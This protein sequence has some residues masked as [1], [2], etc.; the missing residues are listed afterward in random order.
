MQLTDISNLMATL[1]LGYLAN[2][3]KLSN[4]S[5]LPYLAEGASKLLYSLGM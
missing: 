3:A 1:Y 4:V 5:D 2:L